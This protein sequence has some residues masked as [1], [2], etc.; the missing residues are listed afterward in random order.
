MFIGD[1]LGRRELYS[2]DALAI[3]DYGSATPL[4]LTYADLDRRANQFA[5]WLRAVGVGSIHG[6]GLCTF[7]DRTRFFSYRRDGVTGRMACGI[8]L[9][10]D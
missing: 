2:P 6:G 1:Y 3:I 5:N 4:R 10:G 7:S 8:W 9:S